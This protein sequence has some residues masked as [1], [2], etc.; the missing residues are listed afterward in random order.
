MKEM[1]KIG[2]D[3][4]I[5]S[6]VTATILHKLIEHKTAKVASHKKVIVWG[7][8]FFSLLLVS[9][10]LLFFT[11]QHTFTA[12]QLIH[13]VGKSSFTWLFVGITMLT[14]LKFRTGRKVYDQQKEEFDALRIEVIRRSPELWCSDV[15]WENRHIVFEYLDEHFDINLYYE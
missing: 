3:E 1:E 8:C 11:V 14:Y 5:L 15:Q 6:H 2:R 9:I 10:I 7:S 13:I 4:T 12:D